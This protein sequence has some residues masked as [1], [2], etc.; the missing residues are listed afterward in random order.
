MKYCYDPEGRVCEVLGV[1]G[2]IIDYASHHEG[3][4]LIQ[5]QSNHESRVAKWG[6]IEPLAEPVGGA[7]AG[8][9]VTKPSHYQFFEGVEAIEIIASS[10]SQEGFHG[11]CMGN[12]L[13]YRLRAG[14]KDKLEQDI[15]KSDFYKE[16]FDKHKHLCRGA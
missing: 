2:N 7:G 16:L 5:Y 10:M 15:A 12:R 3:Y 11:Y 6:P 8:D 9:V 14:N 1:S 13:K 4:P